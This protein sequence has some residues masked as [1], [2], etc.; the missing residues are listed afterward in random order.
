MWKKCNNIYQIWIMQGLSICFCDKLFLEK[1]DGPKA[2]CLDLSKT[3][4]ATFDHFL[5]EN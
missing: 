1:G 2:I 4:D 3:L 5:H